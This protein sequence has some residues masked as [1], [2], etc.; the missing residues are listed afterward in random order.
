M[1]TMQILNQA[2][3]RGSLCQPPVFSHQSRGI[4]FFRFCLE[5]QRLSGA[6]DRLPV[7]AR[8][9]LLEGLEIAERSKLFVSGE[10]RSFNN[11]SGQGSRLVISVYAR[12][13]ALEEGEDANRVRL[14]GS[15]CKAPT[16][17]TTPLGRDICDLML[18]VNR[19]YGRSDYLPCIAW[20]LKAREAAAWPVGAAMELEGRIQ[21]RRYIKNTEDGAVEKTAFEVSAAEVHL[22]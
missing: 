8:R 11:K 17:R 10:L 16:L 9:E 22:L 13:L 4:D 1:D 21:S 3:L 20:G 12:Q 2:E 14:R 7:L 19:K 15:L 6:V 18:A 5:V